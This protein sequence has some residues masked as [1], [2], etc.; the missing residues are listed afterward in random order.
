MT[1]S[2]FWFIGATALTTLQVLL[3]TAA[4]VAVLFLLVR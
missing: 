1:R 4:C 2:V 3:I